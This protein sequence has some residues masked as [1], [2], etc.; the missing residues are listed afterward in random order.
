MLTR[1]V[2]IIWVILGV[3]WLAK[4]EV[5]KNRLKKKM[6]RSMK[7]VIYGFI[8]FFGLSLVGIVIKAHGILLKIIGLVL[9]IIAL[10]SL[11]LLASKTS[12]KILGKLT[13]RPLVF[14]RIFAALILAIG[15]TL[16][17]I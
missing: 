2:G 16:L 8:I 12:D 17:F 9:I 4:P 1:I 5:L 10:R 3:L 11:L 13:E 7:R 14:F 6:N 15:L